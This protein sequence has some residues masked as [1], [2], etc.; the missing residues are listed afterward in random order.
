MSVLVT[1]NYSSIL[2]SNITNSQTTIPLNAGTGAALPTPTG[3]DFFYVTIISASN[4]TQFEIVRCT[5]RSGDTLTVVRGQDGTSGQAFNASDLVESLQ[6]AGVMNAM[7]TYSSLPTS[8]GSANAQVVTNTVP[9]VALLKGATQIMIPGFTNTAS[10]TLAADGTAATTAKAYGQNLQGG[11]V[12]AGVPA[13]LNFDGTNW[14]LD[15]PQVTFAQ[16]PT[17]TGTAN[18]QVVGNTVN[19][20]KTLV[21]GIRARF[22]PVAANTAAA[23]LNQDGTGVTAL[24]AWGQA[25]IG[26]ELG[27]TT[28]TE[29]AYD[30]TAWEIINPFITALGLANGAL[31]AA[32]FLANGNFT[33]KATANYLVIAIGGG[34]GGGG[35]GAGTTSN[36]GSGGVGGGGGGFGLSIVS[37]VAGTAYAAVIGAGGSGGAHNANGNSGNATTFNSVTI[38]AGGVVGQAGNT[39]I[40]AASVGTPGTNGGGYG[41]GSGSPS[42]VSVIPGGVGTANTGGG[43]GGAGGGN[44]A[45]NGGAGG[46]GGSGI[47]IVI[48]A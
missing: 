26:G 28:P 17:A 11:M 1:N 39:S 34:G 36:G 2:A 40:S 43:G 48:R 35:G 41:G 44:G 33:P 27:S 6:N 21:A 23:T 3:G 12:V 13:Y 30:G 45:N 22:F 24:K 32:I 16:L 9:L 42:Q 31:E 29:V 7:R 47:L 8:T 20:I 14:Q 19:P 25:L 38:A 4:P 15:N 10:M 37:L 18:A 46:A 5:S